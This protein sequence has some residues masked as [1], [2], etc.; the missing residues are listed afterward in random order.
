[1]SILT[2]LSYIYLK[3]L[4]TIA[5]LLI[6]LTNP[7]PTP[8]PDCIIQIPSRQKH[9]TITTHVYKPKASEGAD[10]KHPVLIN[11]YGSGLTIPLHGSD[12]EF[13][14][15]VSNNTKYVVLDV[16]YSLAPESPFPNALQDI[17]DVVI[18]IKEQP[19]Y[20]GRISISGFS[21]G[22]TLALAA[23]SSATTV[24]TASSATA[25]AAV[26][27]QFKSLIAFYPATD[28]YKDPALRKAL[29]GKN[30]SPFWTRIF[31]KA[32]IGAYDARDPRISPAYMTED[33][34]ARMPGF[35]L[36]VTGGEDCSAG[37]AEELAGRIRGGGT[38]MGGSGEDG[39]DGECEKRKREVII[40]RMEGCGHAFD[41]KGGVFGTAKDEVYGEAVR[42][43]RRCLGE[44]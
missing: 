4:V 42:M 22:G 9:R 36:F 44:C 28:L 26:D 34:I 15:L 21:S 41:K 19:E 14:R 10:S 25:A 13:C 17:E 31:R 2:S 30:R 35:M 5:R 16:N 24:S 6:K 33:D 32:Y 29:G 38:G 1:M 23:A 7:H 12:D 37:E 3:L 43:L 39:G 20:D 27:C 40:R 11:L 18:W 8:N